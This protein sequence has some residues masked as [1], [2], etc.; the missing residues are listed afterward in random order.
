M[1][2]ANLKL[3]DTPPSHQVAEPR[4]PRAVVSGTRET[5]L[6]RQ[7]QAG[8]WEAFAE[9]ASHYDS[10]L[11]ALVSRL[12]ATEREARELFRKAFVRAYRELRN[13]RFQCSFYLWIYRIVAAECM[14]FLEEPG[15]NSRDQSRP[16][17]IAIQQLSPRERIVLEL[18]H[19]FGLKLETVAAILEISEA[20]ARNIFVRAMTRLRIS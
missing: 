1:A 13:Y 7:A 15:G 4:L 17:E 9:L 18:K 11:L 6:I 19:S 5:L 16:L 8:R 2:S 20:A 14:H 10:P 3:R 12:T